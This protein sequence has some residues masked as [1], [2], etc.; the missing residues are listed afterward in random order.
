MAIES[1][2]GMA[3]ID[4]QA[5]REAASDALEGMQCQAFLVDMFTGRESSD[6]SDD[7]Y[8]FFHLMLAQQLERFER[9]TG[10]LKAVRDSLW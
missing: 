8:L 3:G 2:G 1:L 7:G 5:V 6:F 9:V 10:V 4:K